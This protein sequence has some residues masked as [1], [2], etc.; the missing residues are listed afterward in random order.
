MSDSI[1]TLVHRTDARPEAPASRRD[2]LRVAFGASVACVAGGALFSREAQAGHQHYETLADAVKNALAR[3]IAAPMDAEPLW[4]SPRQKID[5]LSHMSDR[6]P[7]RHLPTF[8][9]RQ[10][11]LLTVRYEAQ[12]AG[13][14]PEMVLGLIQVESGFRQH[15][16]SSV[17]A[18]GYMQVMPFWTK[19]I[20]DGN[21]D[22]L[23]NRRVNIRYG[24]VILRHYLDIEKGDLFMALGRYNGSRGRAKYP[25]AV[26]A[27]WKRWRLQPPSGQAGDL[28]VSPAPSNPSSSSP[29]PSLSPSPAIQS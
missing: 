20:G 7:R 2:L 6:L 19:V 22:H 26:F 13:L 11:F 24:C 27:A 1:H 21:A 9:A 4:D 12:R 17:G 15:A 10:A 14:D 5:W 3:A 23:F 18:R 16:I 25:D 8:E 29:Q 28:P